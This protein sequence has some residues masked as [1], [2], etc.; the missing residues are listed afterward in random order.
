MAP[1]KAASPI[2]PHGAAEL[3]LVHVAS[4]NLEIKDEDGFVG[5][6]ASR[7]AFYELL[8]ESRKQVSKLGDDP[9]GEEPTEEIGKKRLEKLIVEGDAEAAGFVQGVTEEFAQRL[10]AVIRRFLRLKAWRDVER[11]VIG[12]GFRGGR[13][14]ELIIGRTSI[15]LKTVGIGIDIRPIRHDP[16]E[17]GLIGCVHLAPTWIFSGHDSLVAVDIGGTNFRC[18][19][20]APSL[21]KAADLSEAGVWKS[22]VWRHADEEPS[23]NEAIKRLAKMI[24][25]LIRQ[26]EKRKLKLAPFVGVGCPGIIAADGSIERGGQNLPGNWES[27]RF[28]LSEAITEAIPTIGEH[29]TLVLMH[30]DAVVQGLSEAP[31]MR[32]VKNWGVLTI[33]TGLGNASFSN[34]EED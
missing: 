9:F 22:E 13:V 27:S 2:G 21:D 26:A 28:Q 29:R 17:A 14:G 33:G 18:G 11:I 12:G 8:D 19:I 24:K 32:D 16:D 1:N 30:N 31:F 10:A 3:P 25:G 5:D 6:Q 4:Y 7:T 23:R 15:I 20:V 34:I